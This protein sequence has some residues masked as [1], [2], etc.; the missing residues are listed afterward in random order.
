M[1]CE[2]TVDFNTNDGDITSYYYKD[3][4][5]GIK[6]HEC[7]EC[8]KKILKGEKHEAFNGVYDCTW[9]SY[10]TCE[11]CLSLRNEFFSKGWIFGEV[12]DDFRCFIHDCNFELPEDCI[13]GLTENARSK[14]CEMIETKKII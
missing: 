12:W 14:V 9:Q 5:K 10:R 11:D 1:E 6:D 3:M 8:G 13:S 4:V 2:C 7:E